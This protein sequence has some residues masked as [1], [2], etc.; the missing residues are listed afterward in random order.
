MRR[1]VALAFAAAVAAAAGAQ[2]AKPVL[3]VRPFSGEGLAAT[4]LSAI[5]N[6]VTSYIVELKA[7]RVVDSGGQELALREAETAISLGSP[8][9]LAPLAADYLVSGSAAKAGGIFVFTLDATKVS[10]GE[11]RSV[12]AT[13]PNVNEVIL[14]SRRLTRLL[15]ERPPE[16]GAP[17]SAPRPT[18][19]AT[20]PGATMPPGGAEGERGGFAPALAPLAESPGRVAAAAP[21]LGSLAGTWKGDKGI[22]R[23]SIFADGRGFAILES[24]ASMKIRAS[25]RG[26]D[27]EIVQDQGNIPDFYR[28]PGIDFGA[29]RAIAAKARPWKW[30]F[31]A[32]EDGKTL[33]GLKESVFIRIDSG[34]GV[35]VD[36]GYVREAV[37]TR[38]F[39]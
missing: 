31:K 26:A 39:R 21:S 30:T 6:L 16:E 2:D 5:Q 28:G 24:G 17:G 20:A 3:R 13:H 37:W 15:F 7:F 4:E 10:T 8:K 33:F 22:E 36:N 14:D 9:D 19:T 35:S 27:I 1:L 25:V 23:V 18:A 38:L 12:S 11:K 32:T 34:G 29:A